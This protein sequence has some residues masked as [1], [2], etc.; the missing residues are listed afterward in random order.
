MTI[1]KID[2]DKKYTVQIE[3]GHLQILRNNEPW[4]G[5]EKGGFAASKAW[6]SAAYT[7]E[8][9]RRENAALTTQLADSTT[10]TGVESLRT[11]VQQFDST[12]MSAY[13]KVTL[14]KVADMAGTIAGGM[15]S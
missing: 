11:L 9:L 7:I 8:E 1:E 15:I 13:D 14:E 4:V 2:I 10:R 6:V 12:D 5:Q 3:D